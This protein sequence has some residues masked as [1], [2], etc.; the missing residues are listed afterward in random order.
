MYHE[1]RITSTQLGC[2]CSRS[3][4]PQKML[5]ARAAFAWKQRVRPFVIPQ[6]VVLMLLLRLVGTSSYCLLVL[7]QTEAR[8]AEL[9]GWR[10][11]IRSRAGSKAR[12]WDFQVARSS[13]S[14]YYS[15]ACFRMGETTGTPR[16]QE[17]KSS[18]FNR[19]EV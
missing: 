3:F 4:A 18:P 17:S 12:R 2:F 8:A 10:N 9:M 19:T 5:I 14:S 16:K 6:S 11:V 13:S 1:T 15:L 7:R